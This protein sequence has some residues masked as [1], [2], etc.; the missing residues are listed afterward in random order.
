MGVSSGVQVIAAIALSIVLFVIAFSI[1]N[2]ETVRAIQEAG[3]IKR[4]TVVFKGVKDIAINKDESYNTLDPSHPTF[5]NLGMS[6]NQKGGAEY[7]YNFWMY[8]SS[9]AFPENPSRPN[10]TNTDHGLTRRSNDNYPILTNPNTQPLVLL[11]RGSK[12]AYPYKNLCSSST[13]T[14]MKVD[15]LVKNP[16]IKLENNGD[17][18]TVEINT[19]QSPDGV[20]EKSRDTCDERNTDWEYMNSYRVSLKGFAEKDELKDKWYMV[21]VVV[22]DTYPT[23]P[24]PLRNKVRTRIYINGVLELDKYLDGKLGET[25]GSA[26][27]LKN[28]YGNLH[29]VPDIKYG[30]TSVT[31]N[32]A[33]NS[34][35]AGQIRM[36]DLSYFNYAMDIAEI[37]DLFSSGFTKSMAPSVSSN[38]DEND[39]SYLDSMSIPTGN[40]ILSQL[41][42]S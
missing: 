24:L 41:N 27:I 39:P 9:E 20:K 19:Q 6:V 38:D 16:L 34:A 31:A 26:S 36:A 37:T 29:V 12:K 8:V 40:S 30:N 35:Y 13:D 23:D 14:E 3:K 21:T 15:V 10:T 5:R 32:G 25:S 28:N 22:Q 11:L 7:T 17:V 18:L 4:Q 2:M 42:Q 33:L 1:Y